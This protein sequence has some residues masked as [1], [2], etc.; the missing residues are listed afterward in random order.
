[1]EKSNRFLLW[2]FLVGISSAICGAGYLFVLNR[3]SPWIGP[4]GFFSGSFYHGLI[5]IASGI[6]IASLECWVGPTGNVEMLVDNIHEMGGNRERK[7]LLSLIPAS[8]ISIAA[9]GAM[10]PEAPLVQTTGSLGSWVSDLKRLSVSEKRTLTITGMAAGFTV[11]F[12]APLGASL[13]ALEILHRRGMEYYESLLPAIWGSLCGYVA[14]AVLTR[15]DLRPV[16]SFSYPIHA[17]HLRDLVFSVLCGTLAALA[18]GAFIFFNRVFSRFFK[19]LPPLVRGAAGGLILA[20]LAFASPYALTFGEY[21][22]NGLAAAT[23]AASFLIL[24]FAAKFM[25]TSTTFSSGWKGGFII[26]LFFMGAALGRLL[27]LGFPSAQEVLLVA[28][29]MAA[30]NAGV[31]KTPLG[32]VLVVTEMTGIR[33]FPTTVL[34]VMTAMFLT[35]RIGLIESQR[36]REN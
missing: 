33:I 27:H 1:M 31:T 22:M 36:P 15:M 3:L 30:L 29:L 21:Q 34:S 10:G 19:A 25:G 4:Q 26:P 5:L 32:S 20:L 7:N 14:Y 2:V 17:L 11:L 8:L 9:G 13:F 28:S 12:G 23:P 16:W 18:A 6:A 35:S 24:A